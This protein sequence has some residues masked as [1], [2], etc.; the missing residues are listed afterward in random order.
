MAHV[1]KVQGGAQRQVLGLKR[2]L[3]LIFSPGCK[4]QTQFHANQYPQMVQEPDA[5]T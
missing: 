3:I 4:P 2:G 1:C 5:V